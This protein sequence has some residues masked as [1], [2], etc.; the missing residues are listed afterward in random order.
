MSEMEKR[1]KK[2]KT[3]RVLLIAL[4]VFL[5]LVLLVLCVG[6]LW[7]RDK[8]NLINRDN[9]ENQTT[10]SSAEYEQWL[11]SQQDTIDEN[12]TGEILSGS[13]ITWQENTEPIGSGE[14][15]I[16]ILLIGQDRREGQGRQRSD[17]MILCTV[18][19][20]DKTFTMTSFMRDMYVQIPGYHAN[21]INASYELGGMQLLD[22]TL[23]Q[24]FGV[25]IDGNV[26]VDFDGFIEVIDMLGGIDIELKDYEANYLNRRGNWDVDDSTA[27]QW[28]L[29]A[30]VNHLT[31]E[32]ALAYSRIRYV[33]NGDYE[34]TE[35]QRKVLNI[36]FERCKDLS[37]R[38]L[39]TL[40]EKLL[41][42][43]TTDM[44]N[45]EILSYAFDVFSVLSDLT[46]RQQRIPADGTF[47]DAYIDGMAVL[48]VDME[49]NKELLASCMDD[50][51]P[52]PTEE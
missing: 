27:G 38:E 32:Q 34:R 15:I 5:A 16:N 8:M 22:S 37:V 41:P 26:E 11:Q 2:S 23:K 49:A 19:M 44:T 42:H 47:S 52:E 51:E 10:M 12:Y 40:L 39:N 30:G 14:N 24:N 21:R 25:E 45:S 48:K 35:R 13:D 33:G 36:L 43:V 29:K 18:N 9:G 50:S 17:A 7:L 4:C 28:D 1:N 3:K 46:V 6:G 20:V 31:G